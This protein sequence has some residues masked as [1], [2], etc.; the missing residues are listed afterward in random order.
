M[1]KVIKAGF[2]ALANTKKCPLCGE[3]EDADIIDTM[4]ECLGCDHLRTDYDP[5]DNI[6]EVATVEI[7]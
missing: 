5:L 1:Q 7:L 2:D 3:P 6:D 4:G